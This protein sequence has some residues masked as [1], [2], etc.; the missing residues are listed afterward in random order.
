MKHQIILLVL[1]LT[2]V[3]LAIV[4]SIPK[5]FAP[6]GITFTQFKNSSG[7]GTS[8]TL[9]LTLTA[10]DTVLLEVHTRQGAG[11][12]CGI[13]TPTDSLSNT[14]TLGGGLSF[15]GFADT[16]D[17]AA[18][19]GK[20]FSS[21]SVTGGADTITATVGCTS[22]NLGIDVMEYA[23]VGTVG[24]VAGNNAC[25]AT[26]NNQ[27]PV[28]IGCNVPSN[29]AN[30]WDVGFLG[31]DFGGGAYN[32]V[33]ITD[34]GVDTCPFFCLFVGDRQNVASGS[35]HMSYDRAIAGSGW[36][37]VIS[38][39]QAQDFSLSTNAPANGLPIVDG[40]TNT[41]IVT[42][43]ATSGNPTV[44]FS[45]VTP[46][47]G[48]TCAFSPT[49][50]LTTCTTTL[51]VTVGATVNPA[52]YTLTIQGVAGPTTHTVTATIQV[53]STFDAAA[54]VLA[55]LAIGLIA[56]LFLVFGKKKK[57]RR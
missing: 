10:G 49:S 11:V 32:P 28:S 9:A 27:N 22:T 6:G 35:N 7:T 16:L 29:A 19:D 36:A 17:G 24:S 13:N 31:T 25:L 30:D 26:I 41:M 43:T 4:P 8:S 20:L 48:L 44:S 42:A 51:T 21:I 34:Q 23:H 39:Q 50:C 14:Y 53:I 37:F 57:R 1:C 5:V 33:S 55:I 18:I 52:F 45:C 3:T 38:M 12:S 56:G 40:Q 15:T 54:I 47:T 2:F 46:P